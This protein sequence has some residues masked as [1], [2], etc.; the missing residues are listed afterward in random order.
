MSVLISAI[1]NVCFIVLW[2]AGWVLA[3]GFW[4]TLCSVLLP[5]WGWYLIAEKVMHAMGWA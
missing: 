1:T 3:H 5:P 4:S 2:I